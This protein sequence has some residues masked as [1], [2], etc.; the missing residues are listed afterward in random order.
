MNSRERRWPFA[1]WIRTAARSRQAGTLSE[2][3]GGLIR[4][5]SRSREAREGIL[6][7]P[8]PP[9]TEVCPWGASARESRRGNGDP[10]T[11]TPDSA[12]PGFS[13]TAWIP[14]LLFA[15]F[16]V[17][18]PPILRHRSRRSW[19]INLW[20]LSRGAPAGAAPHPESPPQGPPG[21]QDRDGDCR[22]SGAEAGIRTPTPRRGLDP[23]SS[24]STSSATSAPVGLQALAGLEWYPAKAL[25]STWVSINSPS[26]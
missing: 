19:G 10:S 25:V 24:A 2:P 20:K 3:R 18:R 8:G 1:A 17:D 14:G 26:E 4:C 13:R 5:M 16:S 7:D 12:C 22:K 11:R 15:S 9:G 6:G 21:D 23:E